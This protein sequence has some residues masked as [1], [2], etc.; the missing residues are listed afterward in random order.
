MNLTFNNINF[1]LSVLVNLKQRTLV[2]IISDNKKYRDDPVDF[3]ELL[4]LIYG[5]VVWRSNNFQDIDF[6]I[7]NEKSLLNLF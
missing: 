6:Q 1:V 7:L 4:P 5:E 3:L 2:H